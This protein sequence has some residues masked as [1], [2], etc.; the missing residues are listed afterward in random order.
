MV[1]MSSMMMVVFSEAARLLQNLLQ[2][3]FRI[4]QMPAGL[5]QQIG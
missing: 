2:N 5:V 4:R 3:F 1:V